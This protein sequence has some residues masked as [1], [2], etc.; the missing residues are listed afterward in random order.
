MVDSAVDSASALSLF[1][2][3][4]SI[5]KEAVDDKYTFTFCLTMRLLSKNPAE[6]LGDPRSS[7]TPW[8]VAQ[9]VLMQSLSKPLME[10]QRA[11]SLPSNNAIEIL[12]QRRTQ[13]IVTME[14]R[15][16]AVVTVGIFATVLRDTLRRW[17]LHTRGPPS[18][19]ASLVIPT[20]N[21][22]PF[23]SMM[24][25]PLPFS[26]GTNRELAT[27]HLAK[28]TSQEFIEDGEWTG[29]YSLGTG[30]RI[31][32]DPPMHGI[33]FKATAN[34]DNPATLKLHS[35]GKDSVAP[36]DLEGLIVQ[37]T[38]KIMI[39]K[40]Y[41]ENFYWHWSCVMTPYGIVG[42][43]GRNSSGGSVWLWKARWSGSET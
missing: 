3:L 33:R 37:E 28:M 35:S 8:A 29:F 32:F 1:M 20:A 36:F 4:D 14:E 18:P 15:T 39:T 43:W 12:M 34:N 17:N 11:P 42:S 23:H 30:D 26:P 16:Q 13:A 21:D 25:L 41:S 40:T 6:D 24:D 22:I 27:C 19:A 7:R 31:T 10:P 38:G 9:R 5:R 2:S